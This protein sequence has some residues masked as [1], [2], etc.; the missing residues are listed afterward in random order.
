MTQSALLKAA[1]PVAGLCGIANQRWSGMSKKQFSV[2]QHPR[3]DE[4]RKRAA[5][6]RKSLDQSRKEAGL[7][8]A[9]VLAMSQGND[10]YWMTTG[11]ILK[12][13]W[14]EDVMNN[15]VQPF[16][17][18]Q[19]VRNMHLR[20]IHYTLTGSVENR[21]WSGERYLN[22]DAYWKDL[23]E[24]FANARY[25]GLVR[26]D[27]IRDNKNEFVHRTSYRDPR[28]FGQALRMVR[29]NLTPDVLIDKLIKKPFEGMLNMW[30]FQPVHVELWAEKDLVLLEKVCSDWSLNAVIGEGETSVTQVYMLA[31]RI[32]RARKPA[33]IGYISDCDVVG[34][35][36]VKAMA[37]KLEYILKTFHGKQRIDVKVIPLM[38]TP[39]QVEEL[40]LPTVPM[41]TG[42]KQAYNT[43]VENWLET[44]DM[45]GAVEI[46]SLEAL[47]PDYFKDTIKDFIRSFVDVDKWNEVIDMRRNIPRWVVEHMDDTDVDLTTLEDMVEAV[48]WDQ[49]KTDHKDR[50]KDMGK[51]DMDYEE[52]DE[53][54]SWLLDTKEEYW[55]QLRMYDK[56]DAGDL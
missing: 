16:L 50:V 43:R 27:V 4:A 26:W 21:T 49:V 38:A 6:L 28:T 39:E 54:Y 55:T 8:I 18:A 45:D 47:H 17:T 20:S 10:P 36:M 41:K 14:A 31:D 35:N 46:N 22:T 12:A 13:R 51:S 40:G 5:E 19:G 9:D 52:N 24:A 53:E 42:K 11:K 56:Y 25:L 23:I 1:K 33:R 32:I 44:R 29:E 2:T 30:K 3:Y 37:R 34:S 15:I 7:E 48:D